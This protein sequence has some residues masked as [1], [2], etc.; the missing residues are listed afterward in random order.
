LLLFV[1]ALEESI[2]FMAKTARLAPAA[3]APTAVAINFPLS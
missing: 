3:A 2:I 1:V